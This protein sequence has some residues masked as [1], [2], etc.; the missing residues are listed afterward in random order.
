[1]K[2]AN[3]PMKLALQSTQKPAQQ[4]AQQPA[5]KPPVTSRLGPQPPPLPPQDAKGGPP[6]KLSEEEMVSTLLTLAEKDGE[7]RTLAEINKR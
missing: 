7:W 4:P 1:M 6:V 5:Q 3:P 2:E